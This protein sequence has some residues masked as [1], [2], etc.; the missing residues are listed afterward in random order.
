M[1]GGQT[2][3][4][5]GVNFVT[6]STIRFGGTLATAVVFIDS[7]HLYCTTPAHAEGTVDVVITEPLGAV[8]TARHGFVYTSRVFEED[9]RRAPSITIQKELNG[10]NT[11]TFVVDGRGTPPIGGEK[12]I[13]T[14]AHVLIFA[15]EVSHVAQIIEAAKDNLA[16]QVT[17]TGHLPRFNRKRPFG[18]YN[19]TSASQVVRE[20]VPIYAP[21]FTVEFVQSNL[22]RVSIVLDGEQ[23]FVQV[24]NALAEKIGG[25]HWY[26][27][28]RRAVHFYQSP[29]PTTMFGVFSA[30]TLGPGAA[31]TITES[32]TSAS[33]YGLV[34][35]YYAFFSTFVYGTPKTT[36]T[37]A[38]APPASAGYV[39][40]S[41]QAAA[42]NLQGDISNGRYVNPGDPYWPRGWVGFN[43]AG[44]QKHEGVG[45]ILPLPA[46]DVY[47]ASK[48]VA[49]ALEDAVPGQ[50]VSALSAMSNLLFLR[51][52]L[53]SFA[54][55]P[56]SADIGGSPCTA[57]HIWAVRYGD[58][59]GPGGTPL[60][61]YQVIAD[62]VTASGVFAPAA[63]FGA[64]VQS[65]PAPPYAPAGR[66]FASESALLNSAET[67]L[68]Y[69]AQPGYW[70]Y[71]VTAVYQ[72]GTESR[73]TTQS[74][75]VLLQG[76]F[77]V[78]VTAPLG[79]AINGVPVV[80][81]K[82]YACLFT[83]TTPLVLGQPDFTTLSGKLVAIIPDN[84]TEFVTF[85]AGGA[86]R[87]GDRTPANVPPGMEHQP[88]P[89]LEAADAP[90]AVVDGSALLQLDPPP[91]LTTDDSQLRNRIYLKGK[92]SIMRGDA[93]AG[94]TELLVAD[95]APFVTPSGHGRVIIGSRI[96]D[97]ASIS[98][99]AGAGSLMLSAP[100][101]LPVTQSDWLFGGGLPVRP[102]VQVDDLPSQQLRGA[103]EVDD[104]GLPTDGVH[105]FTITDETLTTYDQMVSRG[106]ADLREFSM[107]L[108][109][110]TYATRD[111]KSLPGKTVHVD[112]TSPPIAGDFLIQD[113]TIDQYHD[114]NDELAPRY[115][116]RASPADFRFNNVLLRA[117]ASAA[118]GGPG[119]S[120]AGIVDTA[121]ARA[122]PTCCK[123][124]LVVFSSAAGVDRL[125][126]SRDA[127]YFM[128]QL[129]LFDL[130]AR[131]DL[132]WGPYTVVAGGGKVFFSTFS[133]VAPFDNDVYAYD[134]ATRAITPLRLGLLGN[135][136]YS[137]TVTWDESRR[138]LYVAANR[139][140][141]GPVVGYW[142]GS[143][144]TRIADGTALLEPNADG[145]Y[146]AELTVGKGPLA[147]VVFT[148]T[149][150]QPGTSRQRIITWS[151]AKDTWEVDIE[152]TAASVFGQID[153]VGWR[154]FASATGEIYLGTKNNSGAQARYVFKRTAAGVWSNITE[155]TMT[156]PGEVLGIEEYNGDLYVGWFNSAFTRVEIW[157]RT[158]AG[159]WSLDFDLLADDAAT[160]GINKFVTFLDRLY[161]LTGNAGY[162]LEKGNTTWTHI[163]TPGDIFT[164]AAV[165]QMT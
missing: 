76:T 19:N 57:R 146:T 11:C 104:A 1:A 108:R 139:T 109:E 80:Y 46:G 131:I 87:G 120:F 124:Y 63:T 83:P 85:P 24:M 118:S 94:A 73:G 98:G 20:L 150:S 2:V 65:R 74:A 49:K 33:G 133:L 66:P 5:Q 116:V 95:V 132:Q 152:L 103:I 97:Y 58:V 39:Q 69:N 153:F 127:A 159:V 34:P 45:W 14:D 112:L 130:D 61:G 30:L 13:F 84:V 56:T 55:I 44:V 151:A 135:E 121:V 32:T 82:V 22:P 100:L 99:A 86:L 154:F 60:Q 51:D 10:T 23:D 3:A 26:I 91:T 140:T 96:L 89:D 72:D 128:D 156:G 71:I 101:A 163:T 77:Q 6:G 40:L 70:A 147:G 160:F 48:D 119:V 157:K 47:F 52:T 17:A 41:D 4:I 31:M 62:N 155:A 9:I 15:G 37:P 68:A 125:Y 21:G 93:A 92:G 134:L 144:F 27:D 111:P 29:A 36:T 8:V 88:G 38:N 64:P 126:Q 122:S 148:H 141:G 102:F 129:A 67:Y 78:T 107:P 18:I 114:V 158:A 106:F 12:V 25:G 145:T 113:V 75:P 123:E 50:F 165:V 90:E 149:G 164:G 35:G 161:G 117:M 42:R 54:G 81:R 115:T 28:D 59:H 16:W 136:H 162:L 110:L 142:D 43:G 7:Q 138:R 79:A 137:T 143:A 105:E 53:P